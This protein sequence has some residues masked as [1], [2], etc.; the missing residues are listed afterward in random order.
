MSVVLKGITWNHSRGYVPMVATSQRFS[1][2]NPG[3]EIVWEKRSLQEFADFPIQKLVD[4]YDLLVIDHPWAGFAESHK[5]LIPLNEYLPKEY[6]ENQ[7]RNSVGRSHESYDFNGFHSALAIDAATPVSS[8]RPD[9]LEK[10]NLSVPATWQDLLQLARK[11][12]VI[13]AGIPIDTLMNLYM[14]CVALGEEPFQSKEEFVSQETGTQALEHLRELT[15]LCTREMFNWNPIKVYEALTSRDEFVY[16]P[17]AYGYSNYSRPGYA[18]NVIH[19][20]DLVTFDNGVK[21]R[22]TLGGTG[23]AVSAS[24]KHLQTA[25]EYAR[26]V[27]SPEIQ[28]T[29]FVE[30]GGQP[31]HR[32]TWVNERVNNNCNNYFLNTL[33]ALDNAYLRPRYNGYLHFQDLAGDPVQAYVRD[34]GSTAAVLERLNELYRESLTGRS[35]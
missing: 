8:Y 34:G 10:E 26:F 2:S 13:F 3:V 31:G 33:P 27:A 7:A 6:M 19:F 11:G 30:N 5:A 29:I 28:Q 12:K 14:F 4:A 18:K 15:S 23:L 21:L 35:S 1:E 25:V 22:S 17:F 20:G 9:L 32:S 24:T 16:C